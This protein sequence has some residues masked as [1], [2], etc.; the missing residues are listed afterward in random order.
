MIK[1]TTKN[2]FRYL[3]FGLFLSIIYD[4]IWF[5]VKLN[6]ATSPDSG[7][8]EKNLRSFSWVMSYFGF[9]LRLLV[10]IVYWKDSMDFDNIM[11]GKRAVEKQQRTIVIP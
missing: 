5:A 8:V 2:T 11:K 7:G 1:E 9:F 3:V 10:F 4:L 6:D